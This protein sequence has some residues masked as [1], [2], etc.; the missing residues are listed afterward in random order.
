MFP[1][2]RDS[3]EMGLLLDLALLQLPAQTLRGLF[4]EETN[5]LT[6]YSLLL[7]LL[8]STQT[9]HG[10]VLTATFD[11]NNR[12]LS[13]TEQA[14][15]LLYQGRIVQYLIIHSHVKKTKHEAKLI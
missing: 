1:L 12:A 2:Q 11:H 3:G 9:T 4:R 15:L 7:L 6:S 13:I 10:I 5:R 8:L 14:M